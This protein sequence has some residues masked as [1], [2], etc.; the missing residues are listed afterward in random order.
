MQAQLA[1]NQAVANHQEQEV[2]QN[3]L[4]QEAM[5]RRADEA[6][7]ATDTARAVEQ[8][9]ISPELGNAFWET[10]EPESSSSAERTTGYS[11]RVT[12]AAEREIAAHRLHMQ[13]KKVERSR[14]NE[15]ASARTMSLPRKEGTTA[16]APVMDMRFCIDNPSAP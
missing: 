1:E 5:R 10:L 11:E 13:A 3:V 2:W 16:S 6:L 14:Q 7:E 15:A 8:A 12:E 9:R 4:E